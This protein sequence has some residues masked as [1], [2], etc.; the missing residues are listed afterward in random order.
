MNSAI[1]D[2]TVP[3]IQAQT[4]DLT[5]RQMKQWFNWMD[6]MLEVHRSMFVFREPTAAQTLSRQTNRSTIVGMA[7]RAVREW[8]LPKPSYR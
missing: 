7:R 5:L 4:R 1:S 3:D 2:S 8:S 6:G